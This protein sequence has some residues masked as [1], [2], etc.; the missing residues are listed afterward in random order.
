VRPSIGPMTAAIVVLVGV[1]ATKTP[2]LPAVV[3]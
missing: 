2:L 3:L 1:P